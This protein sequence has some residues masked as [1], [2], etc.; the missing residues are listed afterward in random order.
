MPIIKLTNWCDLC[1]HERLVMKNRFPKPSKECASTFSRQKI[2]EQK[3]TENINNSSLHAFVDCL[4][5]KTFENLFNL[6]KMAAAG[7]I[8]ANSYMY[9]IKREAEEALKKNNFLHENPASK[10]RRVTID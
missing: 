8:E 4:V 3:N 1:D 5:K 2:V 6:L 7:H 10:S 9:Y